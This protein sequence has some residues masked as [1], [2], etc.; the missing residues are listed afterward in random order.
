M[1]LDKNWFD[2]FLKEK[3]R[4]DLVFRGRVWLFIS[5]VAATHATRHGVTP[6]GFLGRVTSSLAPLANA[7]GTLALLLCIP[8]LAFKDLD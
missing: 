1:A 7:L 3:P 2:E 4:P 5:I 6:N 8:A